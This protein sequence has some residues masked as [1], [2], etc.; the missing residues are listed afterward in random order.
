VF[1]HNNDNLKNALLLA[2]CGIQPQKKT[3][4]TLPIQSERGGI[5]FAALTTTREQP[6][7]ALCIS[8]LANTTNG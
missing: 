7:S 8:C 1:Q 6:A 4:L 2:F 3:A 5:A